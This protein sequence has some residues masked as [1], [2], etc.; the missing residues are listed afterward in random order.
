MKRLEFR[1]MIVVLLAAAV[2]CKGDPTEPLRNGPSSLSLNPQLMYVD[3]SDSKSL[4]VTI[5]DDQLNPVAGTVTVASLNETLATVEPDA[6]TPSADL[7]NYNFVVSGL[8]PGVTK[9]VVSSAGLTDTVD[10]I[11]V[12]TVFQ[13]HFST[14]TPKGGDTV[15]IASTPLLKFDTSRVAVTAI[16]SGQVAPVVFKSADTIRVIA[17]FGGPT[18]YMIAGLSF[19]YIAE[20]V[21]TLPSSTTVTVTGD[22]WAG[23]DAFATAPTIN[24]PG[25]KG[26]A[27]TVTDL[28]PANAASCTS[29]TPAPPAAPV[30]PLRC[31]IYK[32]TL[33]DT[34][35]L[36]FSTTWNGT[37]D[38]DT[39]VCTSAGASGCP[40]TGPTGGRTPTTKPEVIAAF[41]YAAGNHYLVIA[42]MTPPP[43]PPG[44]VP[45]PSP[46]NMM[47]TVTH[48]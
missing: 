38:I 44:E 29:R 41:K 19:T 28:G 12:A 14:T 13:G 37:A 43:P 26:V 22:F 3:Q 40:E 31:V 35:T 15:T 20:H 39:Y 8:E 46:T 47:V 11:V 6:T 7:A 33:A 2:G 10:V 9:L 45:A 30:A 42:E 24:V 4:E 18:N 21:D 5:R 17:P 27:Y 36:R 25:T 1:S 48:P 34:T 32:F 16:A 23:D